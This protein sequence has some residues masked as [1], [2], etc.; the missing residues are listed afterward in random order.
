[1]GLVVRFEKIIRGKYR[2]DII[3]KLYVEFYCIVIYIF[4]IFWIL[5]FVFIF[6]ILISVNVIVVIIILSRIWLVI[7]WV[8]IVK[9]IFYNKI[10]GDVR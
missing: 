8:K 6:K 9:W 7:C 10:N 3:I 5:I 1:M 2:D 4:F